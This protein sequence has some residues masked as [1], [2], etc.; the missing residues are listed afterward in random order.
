MQVLG[1]VSSR[2]TDLG[3][4][5]MCSACIQCLCGWMPFTRFAGRVSASEQICQL[6]CRTLD[7]LVSC[8]SELLILWLHAQT[9]AWVHPLDHLARVSGHALGVV[10]SSHAPVCVRALCGCAVWLAADVLFQPAA[11]STPLR[12]GC[13]QVQEGH[14]EP[15]HRLLATAVSTHDCAQY[16]TRLVWWSVVCRV[17]CHPFWIVAPSTL[18][19]WQPTLAKGV[20]LPLF[21]VFAARLLS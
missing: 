21:V 3:L 20:K 12:Q 5:S 10:H 16:S 7:F 19:P 11:C 2:S 14:Q 13:H 8:S 18:L 4:S 17:C 15:R 6:V 9:P 1:H